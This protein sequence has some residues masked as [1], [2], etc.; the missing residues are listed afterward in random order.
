MSIQ[1]LYHYA[2]KHQ[3]PQIINITIHILHFSWQTLSDNEVFVTDIVA[4]LQFLRVS[5]DA[6]NVRVRLFL[7][8]PYK[9]TASNS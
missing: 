8:R 1:Q 2:Q 3:E 9:D 5:L 4:V 7:Y 6:I